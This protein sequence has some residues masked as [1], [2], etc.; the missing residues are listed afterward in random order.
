MPSPQK[1]PRLKNEEQHPCIQSVKEEL[2]NYY[3]DDNSGLRV[4]TDFSPIYPE[5]DIEVTDGVFQAGHHVI[6]PD[7][8]NPILSEQEQRAIA[9]QD[10]K[11]YDKKL[12]EKVA[13]A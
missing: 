2:Q 8:V 12:Q 13:Q 11:D 1:Y 4:S 3:G 6:V 7:I 9:A 5:N 10:K